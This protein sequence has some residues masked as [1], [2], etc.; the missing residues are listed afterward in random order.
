MLTRCVEAEGGT[1]AQFIGDSVMAFWG[2][3]TRS[4]TTPPAPAGP[5]WRSR[6][7][8][9]RRTLRR[10]QDAPP[11]RMRI[12][13]NTGEVTA[14][15]VGA[16]GRSSY[17]IV[18]DAVNT[19]QRIEQLAKEVCPDGLLAAVLVSATTR[20]GRAQASRSRTPAPMPSGA[21]RSWSASSA[22]RCPRPP[23]SP[24]VRSIC[25]WPP[26]M[27]SRLAHSTGCRGTMPAIGLAFLA[28][29]RADEPCRGPDGA[30]APPV[31]HLVSAV[32]EV[33]VG[34]REPAASCPTRSSAP[35]K[36][37]RSARTA[38]PRST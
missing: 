19:T 3:P 23:P 32:G 6:A 5:P 8:S 24:A 25:S 18:G 38:R 28:A 4:P 1:V 17:G 27:V 16:P 35:A 10:R 30:P 2:A 14:G 21:A 11:V 22:R 9:R 12:G 20:A 34:G 7:L 15:N 29:A 31:A 26:A 36:R 33:R 13:V 37:S